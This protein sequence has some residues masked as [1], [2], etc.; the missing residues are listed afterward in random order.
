MASATPVKTPSGISVTQFADDLLHG[1]G[2][3]IT[4]TNRNLIFAWV[5]SENTKAQNNPLATTQPAAGATNFNS[6]GGYPVK[7][8]PDYKTGLDATIRTLTNGRYNG[9][10]NDLRK[11][12][13]DPYNIVKAN[14]SEFNTWGTGAALIESN[15]GGKPI[16][17]ASI[18]DVGANFKQGANDVGNAVTKPLAGLEKDLL[19][20]IAFVGG[21]LVIL[22]GFILIGADIGIA[23][24]GRSKVASGAGGIVERIRPA[25]NPKL[26]ISQ[27]PKRVQKKAGFSANPGPTRREKMRERAANAKQGD[28][29]PF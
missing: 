23:V 2:A 10:V 21:I 12:N 20:G 19:Y 17:G 13:N 29:V 27:R 15:L 11:G 24:L 1:I 26:P 9:I 3:P 4:Q 5:F 18:L 16:K 22:T 7:N 14:A 6:N 28:E 25:D 8:Y